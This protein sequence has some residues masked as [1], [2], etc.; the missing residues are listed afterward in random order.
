MFANSSC[1]L[2]QAVAPEDAQNQDP[3]AELPKPRRPR[4]E[5]QPKLPAD[6]HGL[7]LFG[8][9][10]PRLLALAAV[11]REQPSNGRVCYCR[12]HRQVWTSAGAGRQG[13]PLTAASNQLA[14]VSTQ[15]ATTSKPPPATSHGWRC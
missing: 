7:T 12:G 5:K 2:L 10:L 1:H 4:Q 9:C 11:V 13:K 6:L 3:N 15:P 14:A 8:G